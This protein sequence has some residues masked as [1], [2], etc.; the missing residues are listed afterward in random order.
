M[1]DR[2]APQKRE[3]RLIAGKNFQAG[4]GWK[5]SV[6]R[7]AVEPADQSTEAGQTTHSAAGSW[8]QPPV[9][10]TKQHYSE[11]VAG[12][13]LFLYLHDS[14]QSLPLNRLTCRAHYTASSH[15]WWSSRQPT[16]PLRSSSAYSAERRDCSGET[17]R[18]TI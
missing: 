4:D 6:R 12:P 2:D 18:I 1:L 5:D 15:W 9:A 11:G 8:S 13:A 7:G 10:S 14:V 3:P 16:A 17:S